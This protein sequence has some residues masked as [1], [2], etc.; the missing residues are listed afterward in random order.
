M[1]KAFNNFPWEDYPSTKS[2]MNDVNLM[3]INNGLD[4]VDNR[5]ISLDTTKATKTE[6]APLI[7]E[8]EFNESNGVFTITRKNGSKFT[9]D[10]KIEKI[11]INFGYD[12]VTQKISLI[13]IDGTVQYIDLSALIT[14]YEF[15]D[16]DT[17]S[18]FVGENGKISAIVKDGSITEDK[19][20]P[21][22]LAEI[23][24]EVAK[25]EAAATSADASKTAAAGS[26]S[27]AAT[28]AEEA[29]ISA[30]NA[31]NS[32][33]AADASKTA[34]AASATT[35]TNKA[36]EAATSATNAANSKTEAATSATNAASSASTATDK[37]NAASQSADNAAA[38]ATSADTY[39]KQSQS[40]AV[41]G[42]GTREGED[43]DNAQYY[44]EQTKRISQSKNGLIP[45]G[46]IS[47]AELSNP[48][49]QKEGYFFDISDSFLSD[50]RFKNGS[51]IF[52]GAGSNVL[53]TAD[54]MWDVTAASMVSGVKGDAETEYRQG[55]VNI[56]KENIGLENVVNERQYSALNP[57]PSVE[58]SSG[59]CTGNSATAT[60]ASQDAEGNDIVDTY[61]TKDEVDEIKKSVSSGKA[62]VASAITAKGITT[63]ATATFAV[64]A[65]NISMISSVGNVE[66]VGN[67]I[68][69]D[70]GYGNA[71]A[72][73]FFDVSD[74]GTYLIV[75][76]VGE[77]NPSS[78]YDGI[79]LVE[80][81]SDGEH[82]GTLINSSRFNA[83][84]I[85]QGSELRKNYYYMATGNQKI[86]IH[87]KAHTF[88][89]PGQQPYGMVSY[90]EILA[91][92]IS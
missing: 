50:E 64:M 9:I 40:Y 21:N 62:Q 59:S 60:R 1:N 8:I 47:F 69:Q 73:A 89:L 13:L 37:A 44:Y 41:G 91:F 10:T 79:D 54:G 71:S 19:L 15:T 72:T 6:V 67:P 34:A 35:A 28:K 20:Q 53:Y 88:Q 43:S 3:K 24:V 87:I 5:V 18:F 48:D 86:T 42:T 39:A 75:A 57:Q 68:V 77:V 66:L 90:A 56:T 55:F 58:G 32:A 29:D 78:S 51:G 83:P 84:G 82:V 25:A 46:T 63:A 61:A 85:N 14:Q 2:P 80:F 45:M 70:P 65:E 38:S 81:K 17:V 27:T 12:P 26:A 23:K 74:G 52:Y 31:A 76:T 36:G 30:D 22:Y 4:E 11:A 92:R 16:T 49:N 33:A 7:K